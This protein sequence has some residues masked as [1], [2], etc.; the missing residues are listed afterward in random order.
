MKKFLKV[1]LSD[2]NGIISSK[3]VLGT[4][5]IL[6]LVLCLLVSAFSKRTVVP[7]AELVY[8]IAGFSLAAFGFST[9]EKVMSKKNDV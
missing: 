2:D 9:I 6:S 7:S 4:L 8:S 5:C 1:M 3:R